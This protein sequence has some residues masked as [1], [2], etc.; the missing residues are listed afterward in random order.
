MDIATVQDLWGH[1]DPQSL[2]VLHVFVD[3]PYFLALLKGSPVVVIGQNDDSQLERMGII[4]TYIYI[5]IHI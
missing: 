5:Y 1:C 2:I 4:Y 3:Y